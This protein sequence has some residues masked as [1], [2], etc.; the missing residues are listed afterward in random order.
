MAAL[1]GSRLGI[2]ASHY[3]QT[4]LGQAPEPIVASTGG[5]P[6]ALAS[7]FEED[8]RRLER[9]SITPVLVF[10]GLPLI[11]A[12]RAPTKTPEA[13]RREEAIKADAWARYENG[14][15]EA[16][17]EVLKTAKRGAWTDHKDLLRTVLRVCRHRSVEY[18]IAPYLEFAQVSRALS[19][20][21]V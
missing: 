14:E 11:A 19:V 8:L 4:V 3:L 12:A 1:A 9:H 6:L 16:A 13:A 20:H 7:K 2:D 15:P 21:H 18:L 5:L 10:A 17:V